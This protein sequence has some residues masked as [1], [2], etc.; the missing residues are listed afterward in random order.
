MQ[1]PDVRPAL[2]R[3]LRI[4]DASRRIETIRTLSLL[5]GGESETATTETLDSGVDENIAVASEELA[6]TEGQGAVP[7]LLDLLES[8]IQKS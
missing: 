1:N 7:A 4:S 3:S 2:L 5:P 6:N 8:S